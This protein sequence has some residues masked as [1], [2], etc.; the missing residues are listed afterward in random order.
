MFLFSVKDQIANI[1]YF[2]AH[3]VFVTTT[4]L[5]QYKSSHRQ[6]INT[7]AQPCSNKTFLMKNES[8]IW[9]KSHSWSISIQYV[10]GKVGN[11]PNYQLCALAIC[12]LCLQA[13]W[14]ISSVSVF[15]CHEIQ[16]VDIDSFIQTCWCFCYLRYAITVQFCPSV[17]LSLSI[18]SD[19]RLHSLVRQ[20]ELTKKIKAEQWWAV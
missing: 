10:N 7:Q 17:V 1:L 16:D 3:M 18:K 13:H 12:R 15:I 4:Q 14:F 2:E 11:L 20:V 6:F 5:Y 9:P 19:P 8:W